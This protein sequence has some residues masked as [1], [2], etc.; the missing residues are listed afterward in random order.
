M[1]AEEVFYGTVRAVVGSVEG[2]SG[3]VDLYEVDWDDLGPEG[4]TAVESAGGLVLA[5]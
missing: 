2:S 5:G 3:D 1:D 4:S